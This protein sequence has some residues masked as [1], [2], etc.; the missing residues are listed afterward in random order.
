MGSSLCVRMQAASA[1]SAGA[2]A[3]RQC[4]SCKDYL[5]DSLDFMYSNLTV[6]HEPWHRLWR[7][8]NGRARDLHALLC[9][10]GGREC[11]SDR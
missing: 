4:S 9:A 7:C 10:A 2:Q 3:I 1:G 11:R 6:I 8:V 5:I